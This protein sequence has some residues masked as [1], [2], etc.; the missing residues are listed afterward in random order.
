MAKKTPAKPSKSAAKKPA[1][2]K[3]AAKPPAAKKPLAKSAASEP[4]SAGKA[5]VK[6]PASKKPV[7]VKPEPVKPKAVKP[8]AVKPKPKPKPAVPK[9]EAE[10]VEAVEAPEPDGEGQAVPRPEP[11]TSDAKPKKNRAGLGVRELEH[12]R[13]LLLQKRAELVGDMSSMEREALQHADTNLSSLPVHMA[14]QGTDAYEQ[15][16]TL[17][18][19]EKDR[20][21]LREINAALVKIQ[22]G[23]Y[24]ICEGTGEPIGQPRLEAQPWAKYSIEHARKLERPSYIR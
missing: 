17:G 16:F 6:K 20:L 8:K 3:S 18:L 19:V 21:L 1:A 11:V 9:A 5:V 22:D 12:F 7:A 2:K 10:P 15:E 4:K 13:H 14:D 23:S 24:G